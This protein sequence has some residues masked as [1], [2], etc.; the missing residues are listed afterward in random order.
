MCR[1]VKT[2]LGA[3]VPLHFTRFSPQYQMK[4]PPTPFETLI[5]CRDI[6]QA[7][8][9]HYVY[10]GNVPGIEGEHT[11][12]RVAQGGGGAPRVSRGVGQSEG[13]PLRFLRSIDP[14]D[15]ELMACW[16]PLPHRGAEISEIG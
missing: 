2:H 7:E 4:R 10:T 12:C 9:L 1:W 13:R 11:Y 14:G 16:L 5:R 6:A 3:D 15:L 8:G